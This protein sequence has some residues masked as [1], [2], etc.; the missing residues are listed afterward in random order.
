VAELA[1]ALDSGFTKWPVLNVLLIPYI[2][3]EAL[4][5]KAKTRFSPVGKGCEVR[6]LKVAQKVAQGK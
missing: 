1:D 4:Q 6:P 5:I 3:A 2:T